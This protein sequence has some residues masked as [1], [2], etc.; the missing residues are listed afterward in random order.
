MNDIGGVFVGLAIAAIALAAWHW[1]AHSRPDPLWTRV[2]PTPAGAGPG[3]VCRRSGAAAGLRGGAEGRGARGLGK[4]GMSLL[5]QTDLKEPEWKRVQELPSRIRPRRCSTPHCRV[6]LVQ[7][8]F[9][10]DEDFE[11]RGLC[12]GCQ[13]DVAATD[14]PVG[15]GR[16]AEAEVVSQD[17]GNALRPNGIIEK[18]AR[19]REVEQADIADAI[20]KVTAELR[21]KGVLR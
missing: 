3:R 11:C 9:E 5:M 8:P 7:R 4:D 15:S 18:R 1:F 14:A 10:L 12:Q 19:A 16:V 17:P 13:D 21:A 2:Q 6:R 20:D